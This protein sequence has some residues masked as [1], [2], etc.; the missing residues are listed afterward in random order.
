MFGQGLTIVYNFCLF[1][2]FSYHFDEKTI[3]NLQNCLLHVRNMFPDDF[4]NILWYRNS[5]VFITLARNSKN[6]YFNLFIFN[7]SSQITNYFFFRKSGISF[8]DSFIS[9]LFP[10]QASFHSFSFLSTES[11]DISA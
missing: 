6:P 9:I 11:C 4:S 5:F 7:N 2:M 3:H 8:L 1:L 10:N